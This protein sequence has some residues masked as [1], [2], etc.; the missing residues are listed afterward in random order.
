MAWAT[1]QEYIVLYPDDAAAQREYTFL[2][3]RQ[4]A[5]EIPGEVVVPEEGTETLEGTEAPSQDLGDSQ[6]AE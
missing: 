5:L 6:A 1:I 3:N 4:G 2:K